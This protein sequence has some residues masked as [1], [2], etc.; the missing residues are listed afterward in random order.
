MKTIL[1]TGAGPNGVTGKRIKEKLCGKY[2]LLTPSSKELDLTDTDAVDAYFDT[3]QIDV[4]V[5]SAVVA[6]SRGHDDSVIEDEVDNNLR[7]YYNLVRH[8]SEFEKMFYFGS[9][10]EYDKSRPICDIKEEQVNE[11]IPLD[12]YGFIKFILN[13]DAK[14]SQNIYNLRLFGT[15]NPYEPYTRN[16]ISNLCAK[17]VAGQELV[18]RRNCRFSF[19]DIDDVAKFIDL[20]IEKTLKYHDYNM[21]GVTIELM[22]LGDILP[23][24][25]LTCLGI[26]F[27]NEG[28]SFE[29]TG[30]NA[31]FLEEGAY[32]TPINESILKVFESLKTQ[33]IDADSMDSRWK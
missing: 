26:R 18:L 16:V 23:N 2:N 19:I 10:A 1:I 17:V 20:G 5:H 27:E 25:S 8:S 6:P 14:K 3:H 12:K 15:I 9:G 32:I 33:V 28:K 24:N 4:V 11:R 21:V 30:S 29:Y 31:R 7:M 22:E 13:T